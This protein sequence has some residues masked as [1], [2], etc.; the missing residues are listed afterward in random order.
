MR[1]CWNVAPLEIDRCLVDESFGVFKLNSI[2]SIGLL[3]SLRL[4][5]DLILKRSSCFEDL[6]SS[7]LIC[8][9]P[10]I[11]LSR[12]YH[13]SASKTRS[14]SKYRTTFQYFRPP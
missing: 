13:L 14:D 12:Q 6:R 2:W 11:M 7:D 3:Y 9:I 1:C 5:S 10:F 8:S 4:L